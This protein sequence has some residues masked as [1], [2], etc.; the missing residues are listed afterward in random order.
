MSKKKTPTAKP[1]TTTETAP[2]E[3]PKKELTAKEKK[4]IRDAKYRKAKKE[5]KKQATAKKPEAKKIA[6]ERDVAIL[7]MTAKI[8]AATSI[9]KVL[10]WN[11]DAVNA[12]VRAILLEAE[13]ILIGAVREATTTM[14][15]IHKATTMEVK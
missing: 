2:A 10:R 1:V 7:A 6:D 3:A 5:A 14:D 15:A 8:T 9:I 13:K 4:R 11:N 12:M